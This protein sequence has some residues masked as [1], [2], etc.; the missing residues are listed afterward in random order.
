MMSYLFG[1]GKQFETNAWRHRKMLVSLREKPAHPA[2]SALGPAALVESPSM[3]RAASG[4][5]A[6]AL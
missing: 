2:D 4:G 6:F 5:N 1:K 3:Q